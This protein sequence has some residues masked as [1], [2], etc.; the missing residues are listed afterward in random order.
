MAT[1][2]AAAAAALPEP[3]GLPRQARVGRLR[4]GRE[5]ALHPPAPAR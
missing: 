4:G 1:P 5:P 2:A 3:Q